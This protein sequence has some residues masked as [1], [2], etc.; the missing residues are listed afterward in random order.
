V[1]VGWYPSANPDGAYELVFSK[2]GADPTDADI[3]LLRFESREKRLV[4]EKIDLCLELG[5][6]GFTEEELRQLL[7]ETAH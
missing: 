5:A 4:Q 2:A 7:A 1:Q 3:V 6:R